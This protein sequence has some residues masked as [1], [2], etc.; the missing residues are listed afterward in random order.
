MFCD[1]LIGN[2]CL[3]V[4][5]SAQQTR[6]SQKERAKFKPKFCF[7]EGNDLLKPLLGLNRLS[8]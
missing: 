6:T 8:I 5:T 7:G 3:I 4:G 2:K 1:E